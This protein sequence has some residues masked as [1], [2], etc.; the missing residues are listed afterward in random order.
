MSIM[1]LFNL[2]KG[3]RIVNVKPWKERVTLM[4]VAEGYTHLSK[5]YNNKSNRQRCIQ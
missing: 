2:G 1:A 3:T 4:K 5:V